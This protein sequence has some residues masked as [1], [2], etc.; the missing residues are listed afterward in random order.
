MAGGAS[1]TVAARNGQGNY[2]YAIGAEFGTSKEPAQPFFW[3]S[4]RVRRRAAREAITSVTAKA[5]KAE[6]G[7]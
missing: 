3:P 6:F 7:K 4:Y 2:N 5:L 1:T